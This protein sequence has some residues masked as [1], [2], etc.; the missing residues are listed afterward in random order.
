MLHGWGRNCLQP[1][2]VVLV[3][4]G[5]G[6]LGSMAIQIARAAGAI[7]IAVVSGR[8]KFAFCE[9]LG[10]QGCI[11]R[12]EFDHWGM[13][14]H[15]K[16]AVGYKK[17]LSGV[18]AF[19]A[20]IWDILG[21]KRG[22]NIVFEHPG[23]ST[24]PT[25][26]FVCETGGIVAVCAGTTGYNATVDLRYLWMRQKRLQGSHFA[27]DEQSYAMN[28]LAITGKLDP[29][30]SRTFSFAELPDAHQLMHE[31][32]HPHGNMAVLVGAP[33]FGLG[34]TS[35]NAVARELRPVPAFRARTQSPRFPWSAPMP[36][37]IRQIGVAQPVVDDDGASVA[38]LMTRSIVSCNPL[39]T[40]HTAASLMAAHRINAVVVMKSAEAVG[41]VSQTD[42]VLARQGRTREAA[43]ELPV[44]DV[45]TEG[46][47]TC[48]VDAHLSDAITTM[49]ALKIHRLVVT[50]R[51]SGRDVP[52][53]LLSMTDI[54]RK[55]M[56]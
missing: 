11:D 43:Q 9:S 36:E 21:E 54:V 47:V 40:V 17:W 39:D 37:V 5:A 31:N 2:D 33:E 26:M 28:H 46:C 23:E 51:E 24:L 56:L 48:D 13:L 22:P 41:V 49:T 50:K 12:T 53:G 18:R 20:K 38:E 34:V 25:S 30:L 7:P 55:V 6:G 29:C 4:G 27:N 35:E 16:D 19:G 42:V 32:L 52:V 44:G 3:W 45:M 10:A 14:P 1:D 15:W 8:E